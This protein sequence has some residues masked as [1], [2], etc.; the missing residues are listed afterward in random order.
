MTL[1]DLFRDIG[2]MASQALLPAD[3]TQAIH[4]HAH[5]HYP[6]PPL[7]GHAVNTGHPMVSGSQ[8]SPVV[9]PPLH[10][11]GLML[12]NYPTAPAAT[13]ENSLNYYSTDKQAS[14]NY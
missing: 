3:E 4:A 2:N 11:V 6:S 13:P 9:A 12:P 5:P 1:A 7:A 10:G 14:D 8:P